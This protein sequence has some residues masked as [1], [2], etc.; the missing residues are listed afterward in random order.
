MKR[1]KRDSIIV[2]ISKFYYDLRL[3]DNY[4]SEIILPIDLMEEMN[5]EDGEEVIVLA[6]QNGSSIITYAKTGEE[7][8]LSG[9]AA[10]WANRKPFN[11]EIILIDLVQ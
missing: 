9:A 5:I 11:A 8:S 3:A 10:E 4:P 7:V 6:K 2:F 1:I